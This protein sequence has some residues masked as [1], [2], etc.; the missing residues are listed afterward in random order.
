[1]LSRVANSI[2]WLGR[3][4]ERSE[5]YARFIDVNYNLTLDLPPDTKEQWRPLVTVTGDID[6]YTQNYHDFDRHNAIYFLAFDENNPNSL[7]SSISKARENARTVREKLTKESWEKLNET[8]LFVKDGAQNEIWKQEDPREFFQDMKYKIQLLYGIED[9]SVARTEE[10]YFRQLGQFLERAD[11]TSRILDVKYHILLPS[12]D[13]IGSTLDILQWMALLKSVSAFNTYRRVHG[14]IEPSGVVEFLVL[15]KYFPRSIFF[16]LSEAEQCLYKIS[17]SSGKGFNN[18]AEKKIGSLRS[19]LEYH[20]VSDVI[21]YGLHEYLDELQ[22]NINEISNAI[23]ENFF[24][25]GS[26]VQNQQ[27]GM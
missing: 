13:E 2:Y 19:Q 24:S 21:N 3:Y 9:N 6:L 7:F 25:V 8:Y 18:S 10:W 16:C 17:D 5:N 26:R 4:L 12:P 14:N 22:L 11:K 27:Q 20:D 23:H 1:M 15:N